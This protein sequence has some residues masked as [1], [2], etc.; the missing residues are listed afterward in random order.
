MGAIALL[1]SMILAAGVA[2][3]ALPARADEAPAPGEVVTALPAGAD[4]EP[5][6]AQD[7]TR[8]GWYLQAQG[9][10]AFQ[11][12]GVKAVP[13]GPITT[14]LLGA[15]VTVEDID[16]RNRGAGFNLLA[17]YRMG[18]NFAGE[19]EFEFIESF[20]VDV[21]LLLN[22]S[23]STVKPYVRTYNLALNLRVYPLARLFDP[24]SVFN[25]FQPFVKVGPAWQYA[26]VRYKGSSIFS[27]GGFAG[28]FGAGLDIYITKNI[29]F[30]TGANYMLPGG[31]VKGFDY[32]SIGGGLQYR[33][34]GDASAY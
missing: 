32:V 29:V 11:N 28:R 2:V 3:T 7:F 26:A 31:D 6:P 16:V 21:D 1:T 13:T 8:D 19:L 4:E 15:N 9:L 22:G 18:R 33:F 20:D 5:P 25:R 14:P 10:F 12:F 34:G 30:T 27:D 17:G 24:G 23:P